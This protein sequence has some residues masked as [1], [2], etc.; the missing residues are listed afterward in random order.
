MTQRLH[1]ADVYNFF[2]LSV[3]KNIDDKMASITSFITFLFYWEWILQNFIALKTLSHLLNL[4]EM[5]HV[6]IYP[7]ARIQT[8]FLIG[9]PI[10]WNLRQIRS[11]GLSVIYW[12]W[13][14]NQNNYYKYYL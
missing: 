4:Q 3:E 1:V 9:F 10:A 12:L 11:Q 13:F 2:R 5:F 8:C 14:K 7:L 6:L